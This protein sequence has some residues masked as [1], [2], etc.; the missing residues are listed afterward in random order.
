MLKALIFDV[1]GTLADTEG[2]QRAAFNAAFRDAGLEWHWSEAL[3]TE[4]LAVSGGK[5][6]IRHYWQLADPGAA[7]APGAAAL[8]DAVH[9]S[10]TRHYDRLAGSG[11]L[12]LRPGILRLIQEARAARL[13]VA[14][15]TT[16]TPANIDALLRTPLGANW[17][18]LFGAVCDADTAA[19]KKPAP[20]VYYAALAALGLPAEACLAFEDS[21]NGLLAA[22]AAGIPTL[23]TPTAY[24]R[25][26]CFDGALLCL[27]DLGEVDLATLQRAYIHA[28]AATQ[29][30]VMT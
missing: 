3:Y 9:A 2:A 19:V 8:I 24:T 26:Q 22:R 30:E 4:L 29:P 18:T 5:E 10:K 23:V 17:R 21:A 28:D 25:G 16:T 7:A 20:D 27:D 15:A 13:A 1:D 11:Q 12:A 6:R 14:I